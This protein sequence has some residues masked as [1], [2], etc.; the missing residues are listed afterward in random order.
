[1][2]ALLRQCFFISIITEDLALKR[3]TNYALPDWEKSDFIQ[4]SDFNDLTHKLDTALKSHDDTL[5]TKTDT[6]SVTAVQQEVAAA[7]EANCLVKLAGPLVTTAANAAM[8]FDLSQV[9][10]TKVAALFVVFSAGGSG[11]IK[12]SANDTVVSS[13]CSNNFI[14]G[15]ISIAVLIHN[16]E[17]GISVGNNRVGEASNGSGLALGNGNCASVVAVH[18]RGVAILNKVIRTVSIHGVGEDAVV[19]GIVVGVVI[20]NLRSENFHNAGIVVRGDSIIDRSNRSTSNLGTI[21][22]NEVSK[23]L[24]ASNSAVVVLPRNLFDHNVVNRGSDHTNQ[25]AIRVND[26]IPSGSSVGGTLDVTAI[27]LVSIVVLVSARVVV[28]A[29]VPYA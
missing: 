26:G 19:V 5:N 21:S 2:K 10:M 7:R 12:L 6:S 11:E 27:E 9:D 17:H 29:V 15:V 22:K 8:E 28:A 14:I 20:S 23:S 24:A 18:I 3:T 1:M 4:M 13:I 25:V 16:K